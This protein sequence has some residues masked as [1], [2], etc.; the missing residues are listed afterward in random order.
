MTILRVFHC[1]LKLLPLINISLICFQTVNSLMAMT[2]SLSSFIYSANE[3]QTLFQGLQTQSRTRQAWFS[4]SS[5]HGSPSCSLIYSKSASCAPRRKEDSSKEREIHVL[6][7]S[8]SYALKYACYKAPSLTLRSL[9]RISGLTSKQCE[10]GKSKIG[11]NL[12]K[13]NVM[14]LEIRETWQKTQ[15]EDGA[16]LNSGCRHSLTHLNQIKTAQI[17][18]WHN[19]THQSEWTV[20]ALESTLCLQ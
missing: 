19:P 7:S 17:I 18:F 2:I 20:Y 14:L 4:P 16:A 11:M 6:V 10:V 1:D 8:H 3:R 9:G 13:L 12:Q 5:E 15:S